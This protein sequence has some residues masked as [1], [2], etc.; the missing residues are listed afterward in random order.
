M[1]HG[2]LGLG[3]ARG[4]GLAHPV[5]LDL[6]EL[7]ALVHGHDGISGGAGGGGRGLVRWFG[8]FLSGCGGGL[9]LFDIG[10]HDAAMRAGALDLRQVE[11][12]FRGDPTGAADFPAAEPSPPCFSSLAGSSAS[13]DF[14][15]LGSPD[16][17][18]S[19]LSPSPSKTAI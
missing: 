12:L 6:L 5:E 18:A 10:A 7:A 3:Q 19:A 15:V 11:A 4:D 17:I 13:A 9:G 1:R 8:G 16:L 2:L 14:G